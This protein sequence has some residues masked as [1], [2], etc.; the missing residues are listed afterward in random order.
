MTPNLTRVFL[1]QENSG[2]STRL[3]FGNPASSNLIRP[4]VSIAAFQQDA[5]FGYERRRPNERSADGWQIF[6]LKAASP[7][8]LASRIRGIQPGAEI[9]LSALNHFHARRAS[10]ALSLVWQHT[11]P[12]TLA[13]SFWLRLFTQLQAGFDT[14]DLLSRQV[15]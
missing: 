9:L 6:I 15:W 8:E 10:R 2:L 13:P 5:V 7:G 4:G 11:D 12:H 14:S 3:L 1:G